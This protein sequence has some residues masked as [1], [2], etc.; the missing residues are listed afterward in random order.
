M[1]KIK[2]EK[3]TCNLANLYSVGI[4]YKFSQKRKVLY[5]CHLKVFIM[6][7]KELYK[8]YNEHNTKKLMSKDSL[9]IVTSGFV[10]ESSSC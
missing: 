10:F 8:F 5:C 3:I 7:D 9:K 1:C 2:N 4:G 6:S